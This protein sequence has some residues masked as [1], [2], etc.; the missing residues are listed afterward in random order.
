LLIKTSFFSSTSSKRILQFLNCS[1]QCLGYCETYFDGFSSLCSGIAGDSAMYSMI[2]RDVEP[3]PCPFHG[4][5]TFSY[6][7]GGAGAVC[8][9]PESYLD[10]CSDKRSIQLS[11]QACIDVQGSEISSEKL[12]CL[13][14]KHK[15]L[16]LFLF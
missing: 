15:Y 7:K 12:T 13:A 6:A 5:H 4:P 11:F 2:R 1:D 3:E 16:I 14:G 9:Y 10:S 8:G